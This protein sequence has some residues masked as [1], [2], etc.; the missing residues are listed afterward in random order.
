M[1]S[2]KEIFSVFSALSFA[3]VA[4]V[5]TVVAGNNFINTTTRGI[6][7]MTKQIL[8]DLGL[9]DSD[10]K[11]QVEANLDLQNNLL[12]WS[13]DKLNNLTVA[14]LLT[15][16]NK[17]KSEESFNFLTG[18]LKLEA[19]G[20]GDWSAKT[21]EKVKADAI[22][23]TVVSIDPTLEAID[24][25]YAVSK[26][27]VKVQWKNDETDFGEYSVNLKVDMGKG[28]IKQHLPFLSDLNW[29]NFDKR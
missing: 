29:S 13:A 23:L 22:S 6:S 11:S 18:V 4:G 15:D 2:M 21:F 12:I 9:Y 7:S 16:K 27:T 28:I 3:T 10:G 17:A 14:K 8:F 19:K 24:D 25:D 5:S 20:D 26:G 1:Q